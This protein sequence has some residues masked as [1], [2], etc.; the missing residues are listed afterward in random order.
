MTVLS[1]ALSIFTLLF[2]SISFAAPSETLPVESFSNETKTGGFS[3]PMQQVVIE[4]G[5]SRAQAGPLFSE[6]QEPG[7]LL[8]YLLTSKPILYPKRAVKRG[9]EGTVVVAVEVLKDGTVGRHLITK[10]TGYV[11]LDQ[12]VI[13]AVKDWKFHPAVKN[14]KPIVS[15]IQIPIL[16]KL[17]DRS[18]ENF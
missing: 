10:S 13:K 2:F 11:L 8:P 5:I 18:P 1:G 17:Q 9:W 3:Y 6:V 15:C 14:D 16:F 4:S 12:A 7:V